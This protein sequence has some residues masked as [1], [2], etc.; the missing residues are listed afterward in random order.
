MG[1]ESVPCGD[2][3]P[4]EN[5]MPESPSPQIHFTVNDQAC[6]APGGTHLEAFLHD[7]FGERAGI[8]IAL[9]GT[10]VPRAK[11]AAT[12]LSEGM[13]ILIIEATQGG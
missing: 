5:T 11:W 12:S 10:V 3:P 1:K 13:E 9:D 6:S 2:S 8:A 4:T 7:K